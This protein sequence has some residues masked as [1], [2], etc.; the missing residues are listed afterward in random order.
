MKIRNFLLGLFVGVILAAV[1]PA[2]AVST[3]SS[4]STPE[5]VSEINTALANPSVT[6]LTVSGAVTF[7]G[8]PTATNGLTAGK[9]WSDSG[10]IKVY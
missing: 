5:L 9:L 8:L 2:I 7:S 3:V 6:T 4:H 10:T 1:V